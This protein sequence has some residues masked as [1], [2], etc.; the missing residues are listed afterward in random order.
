MAPFWL[1][2]GSVC[3][4]AGLCAFA[5]AFERAARAAARRMRRRISVRRW[6]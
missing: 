3:V 2:V 5:W 4:Y 1:C 6:S